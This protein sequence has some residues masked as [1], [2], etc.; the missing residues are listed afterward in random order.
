MLL[1]YLVFV[2]LLFIFLTLR[3][4]LA[5]KTSEFSTRRV[6]EDLAKTYFSATVWR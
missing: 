5:L 6:M 2:G 4:N 1:M 3:W